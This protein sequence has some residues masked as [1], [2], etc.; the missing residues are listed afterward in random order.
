MP[1]FRP[2]SSILSYSVSGIISGAFAAYLF[3]FIHEIYIVDI[4]FSLAVM[5]ASAALCGFCLA[6]SYRLLFTRPSIPGW[7]KYNAVYVFLFILLGAVSVIV[8]E[9]VTTVAE[10]ISKNEPPRELI[11]QAAPMTLIFIIAGTLI[12]SLIYSR[13]IIH[14]LVIFITVSV[15]IIFLGLNVSLLGLVFFPGNMFYLIMEMYALILLLN[16]VF[17]GT[18]MLIQWKT[19]RHIKIN[20]AN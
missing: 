10:L 8:F 9:P 5:M 12:L 3:A 19:L 17:G 18:F 1:L 20:V 11:I 2:S 4:W 7:W 16:F 6:W 14:Y 15:L 13:K